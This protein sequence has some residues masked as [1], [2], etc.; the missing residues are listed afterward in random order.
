MRSS[1]LG[2]IILIL[3]LALWGMFLKSISVLA[4]KLH[5]DTP[6]YCSSDVLYF[7]LDQTI[8]H[9]R[10]RMKHPDMEAFL[11]LQGLGFSMTLLTGIGANKQ[12]TTLRLQ[13]N[14][15]ES[16]AVSICFSPN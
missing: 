6:R 11:Y 4:K 8:S 13:T 5:F 15:M 1:F 3:G 9:D 7:H 2:E 10:I 16:L 14:R 12:L